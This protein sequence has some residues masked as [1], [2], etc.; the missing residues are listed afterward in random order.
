M[1]HGEHACPRVSP[2]HPAR[3]DALLRHDITASHGHR[4]HDD[5]GVRFCPSWTRPDSPAA[6]PSVQHFRKDVR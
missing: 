5:R 1:K 4:D 3:Y 6:R 2:E